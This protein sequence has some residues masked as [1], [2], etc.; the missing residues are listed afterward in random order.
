MSWSLSSIPIKTLWVL[1][2]VFC[3][4]S[5]TFW[6]SP[7][8]RQPAV[9]GLGVAAAAAATAADSND[10]YDPA[11]MMDGDAEDGEEEEDDDDEDE[12]EY[13]DDEYLD[14]EEE[15]EYDDDEE[16]EAEEL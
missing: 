13:D 6:L 3:F 15:D 9:V 2:V 4:S 11:A 7:Q 14:D 10:G 5:P 8:Q 16:E 12:D 1:I